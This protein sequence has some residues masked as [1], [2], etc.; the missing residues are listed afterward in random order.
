MSTTSAENEASY[1]HADQILNR[2]QSSAHTHA[3]EVSDK[4]TAE[5][6]KSLILHTLC[7]YLFL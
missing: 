4:F 2:H 5:M 7:S 3:S 6:G 1:E